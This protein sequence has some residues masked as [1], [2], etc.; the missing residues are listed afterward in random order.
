ME[1][2]LFLSLKR[3][4]LIR[5]TRPECDNVDTDKRLVE[6]IHCFRTGPGSITFISP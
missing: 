2:D 6:N 5:P 4:L 3:R 1:D